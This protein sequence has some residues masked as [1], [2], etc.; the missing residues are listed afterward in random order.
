LKRAKLEEWADEHFTFF[1]ETVL[2][3]FVKIPYSKDQ[4]ML[5]EV[6]GAKEDDEG[7]YDFGKKK[8]TR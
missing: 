3:T 8:T 7:T 5:A 1:N 4:Y 2:G 6:I